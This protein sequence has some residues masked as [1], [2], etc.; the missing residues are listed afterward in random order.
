MKKKEKKFEDK[1]KA[2]G[3]RHGKEY[4]TY[5]K[6][7]AVGLEFGLSIAVG[8]LGGY[9]VDKYFH[10]SP[11]GLIIGVLFGAAA[12]IKRLIIFTKS[13]VEKNKDD[14]NNHD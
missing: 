9:F 2:W 3:S 5:I 12:G 4:Q 6:T 11:Y 1:L 14:E 10:I 13:Y 8:A 7:S